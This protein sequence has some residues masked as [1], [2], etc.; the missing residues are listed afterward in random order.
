[1]AQ[2]WGRAGCPEGK[3]MYICLYMYGIY[4]LST[5]P[6]NR[7]VNYTGTEYGQNR[8]KYELNVNI[9]AEDAPTRI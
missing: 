8:K 1:M 2:E 5:Y 3:K 6:L 7:T 4:V 9:N